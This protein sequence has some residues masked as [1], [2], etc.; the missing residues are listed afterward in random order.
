MSLAS[1]GIT[2]DVIREMMPPYHLSPDLLEATFAALPPPPH[3]ASPPWRQARIARLMQEIATLMPADAA[4]ARLA[5]QILIVRELA[6]TIAARAYCAG[7]DGGADV[8]GGTCLGRAG[9][10]GDGAAA[11]AGARAAE[12][13]GVLWHRAGRRGRCR[14]AGG[15]VGQGRRGGRPPCDR[16]APRR[17]LRNRPPNSGKVRPNLRP[18]RRIASAHAGERTAATAVAAMPGTSARPGEGARRQAPGGQGLP[19]AK[20]QEIVAITIRGTPCTCQPGRRR[21]QTGG[22][23]AP[24]VKPRP[25]RYRCRAVSPVPFRPEAGGGREN[26]AA[27]RS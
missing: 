16:T 2:P 27:A 4:Q 3:A 10:D 17:P 24:W 23:L 11:C 21:R 19:A 6:D 25:R 22:P 8:P 20:R 13:G 26:P 7:A 15:G 5:A 9:A 12:A 1:N 18:R 14:G